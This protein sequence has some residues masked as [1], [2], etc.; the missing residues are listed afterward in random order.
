[1]VCVGRRHGGAWVMSDG[2]ETVAAG[3]DHDGMRQNGGS[4]GGA[5]AKDWERECGHGC[6]C[7]WRGWVHVGCGG[8]LGRRGLWVH[9][10]D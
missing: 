2:K 6:V 5:V 7:R 1:M 8:S 4:T 9:R 10:G 3:R